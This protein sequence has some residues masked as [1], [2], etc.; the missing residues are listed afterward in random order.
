MKPILNEH[1]PDSSGDNKEKSHPEIQIIQHQSSTQ[2][3]FYVEELQQSSIKKDRCCNNKCPAYPRHWPKTYI[4][5]KII[6]NI[7]SIAGLITDFIFLIQSLEYNHHFL[8]NCSKKNRSDE[9]CAI[10]PVIISQD[11]QV[12]FWFTF[13]MPLLLYFIWVIMSSKRNKDND[14]NYCCY[15][16]FGWLIVLLFCF[17]YKLAMILI[18]LGSILYTLQ[19]CG[20]RKVSAEFEK[21]DEWL[22]KLFFGESIISSWPLWVIS[23]LD[24]QKWYNLSV[25]QHLPHY[26]KLL[27]VIKVISTGIGILLDSDKLGAYVAHIRDPLVFIIKC[28]S[29]IN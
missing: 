14:N 21:K 7:L 28:I 25:Y 13:A 17:V 1:S 11:A 10:S 8:K 2:L 9:D 27:L 15:Y 4:S 3:P 22:S 20:K 18:A 26:D 19:L 23:L 29:F 24:L 6:T 5:I 12:R 16:L